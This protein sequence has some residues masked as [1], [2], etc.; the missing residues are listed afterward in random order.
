M[1]TTASDLNLH[2]YVIS[3]LILGWRW[4]RIRCRSIS[5]VLCTTPAKH[6]TMAAV[7][8]RSLRMVSILVTS[9]GEVEVKHVSQDKILC[10]FRQHNLKRSHMAVSPRHERTA[11]LLHIVFKNGMLS[12]TLYS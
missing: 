11:S 12:T 4:V 9:Q 3:G 8:M 7:E 1:R 10:Y 5:H 6:G 2:H